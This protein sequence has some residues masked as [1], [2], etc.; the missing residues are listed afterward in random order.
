[1][2]NGIDVASWQSEAYETKGLAFVFVKATEGTSYINPKQNGQA[3]RARAAGL[4]LGFYHFLLPGT[5]KPVKEQARFFV[6]RC[7]SV[8]GDMLVCDWE[9]DPSTKRGA[10][11][12]EKDTFIRE[13]KRLRPGHRVGLYC[14][15]D[16]WLHRDTTSYAGDFL[17]IADPNRAKGKPRIQAP[18]KFH[19]HSITG[20][21][22]QNVGDFSSLAALRKW[23]G[24]PGT[25]AP[26]PA[27]APAKTK[28]QKQDAAIHELETRV[29]KLESGK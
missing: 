18:W 21:T 3:K 17:W 29:T 19:Q 22:D 23:C 28:D 4:A 27:P 8:E 16:Y 2:I 9:T 1:M 5:V 14:N 24:Y 20:G 7:A 10:T 15:T 13:V 25:A 11:N 6:D 12:A 26:K